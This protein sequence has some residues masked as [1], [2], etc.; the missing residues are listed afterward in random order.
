LPE[1]PKS[2]TLAALSLVRAI[3]NRAS[4]IEI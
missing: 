2:S 4:C 3:Q 1:N